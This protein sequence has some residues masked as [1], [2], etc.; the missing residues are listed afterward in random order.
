[1]A[2]I[3]VC[4]TSAR[5]STATLGN[6]AETTYLAIQQT[7]SYLTPDLLRERQLIKSPHQETP[8]A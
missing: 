1:M 8:Q 2:G 4:Y 7:Y 3:E 6:F 5:V